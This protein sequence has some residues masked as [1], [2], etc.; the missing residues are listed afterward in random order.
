M[1]QKFCIYKSAGTYADTLEA[2]GLGNL[3]R[4]LTHGDNSV[5][6][7]DKGAYFE[8]TLEEELTFA[9]VEKI[10]YKNFVPFIMKDE[11]SS[12]EYKD[13]NKVNFPAQKKNKKEAQGLK[14]EVYKK[15]NKQEQKK[16]REDNLKRIDEGYHFD[17]EID[18]YAQ[19]TTNNNYVG[20]LKIFHNFYLNKEY[21]QDLVFD[22]LDYYSR[23][24]PD[25]E[26]KFRFK[27]LQKE[28]KL[29][30]FEE[31][32][33]A[34]Q[35]YNPNQ[36]KGLNKTKANGLNGIN[37][38]SL[39]IIETMK[40]LGT[41]GTTNGKN[42]A[43]LCQLV[44]VGNSYDLKI[45]VPVFRSTTLGNKN[46]LFNNFKAN[47]RGNT[48]ISIDI[49]NIL[50]LTKKIIENSEEYKISK[51]KSRTA[52]KDIVSGL[53]N[54]YQKDLGN[55]RA[56]V[57][58]SFSNTPDFIDFN[59][60]KDAD[61]WIE[62]LDSQIAI[63]SKIN[64]QLSDAILGLI[65]YRNFIG[66]S[67]ETAFN[68]FSKFTYWYASYLMHQLSKDDKYLKSFRV[69]DLDKLYNKIDTQMEP[70]LSKIINNEGFKAIALAI[71][72]STVRL[73]RMPKDARD[74]EI[75]YG[76]VQDLQINSRK[77]KSFLG[78]IGDFVTKYNAETARYV[79]NKL[80]KHPKEGIHRAFIKQEEL[81]K[82][83]ALCE[84]D[85]NSAVIASLLSSYGFATDKAALTDE[86]KLIDL[87]DKLGYT[88]TK[89]ESSIEEV[90]QNQHNQEDI[91]Q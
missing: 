4:E 85:S 79:E 62:F 29:N 13:I 5:R 86:E 25:D 83:Y 21:Y 54:V 60:K 82:F 31:E 43:M 20:F 26:L 81:D 30:A 50:N 28:K 12:N 53:Q 45:S 22:I 78:F 68:H 84:D 66:S 16:E 24:S 89:T 40:L 63:I 7:F 42:S 36:G 49:L 88:L 34:I 19:L 51:I 90:D 67:R 55:N 56:V 27:K 70:K 2:Y 59:S 44:K 77:M 41:V 33:T 76:F 10:D 8:I 48:P 73:Q 87:A 14:Q 47:L 9:Q 91:N 39:W 37:T 18:I 32:I 69:E 38:Q 17:N 46:T 58:I 64:E 72:N 74:F 1:Y 6:L 57:N 61:E 11:N 75:R 23:V 3:L 80:K 15:Y 71:R 65:T 35:L 52:V